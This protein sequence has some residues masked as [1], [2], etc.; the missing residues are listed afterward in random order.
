MCLVCGKSATH[1]L[2]HPVCAKDTTID[3]CFISIEYKNIAKKLLFSFKYKPYL[4]D[5]QHV[6]SELL[7]EGM[8]QKEGLYSVLQKSQHTVVVPIPLHVSKLRSRGYNHAAILAKRF[9]SRLHITYRDCMIRVRKTASQY[10]LSKKDRQK[11]LKDAFMVPEQ[12]TKDVRK[13]TVFVVDDIVTTGTTFLEAAKVLKRNGAKA[14]YGIALA[15][16]N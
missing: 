10:G 5:L 9:A 6:L 8:V 16:E 11:N 3:G 14:V 2:T 7:Y 1:G 4:S 15:G 13:A 12:K